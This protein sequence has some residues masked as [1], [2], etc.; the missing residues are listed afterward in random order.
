M[1]FDK[2]GTLTEDNLTVR[3]VCPIALQDDQLM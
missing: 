2:T 3:G 1:C